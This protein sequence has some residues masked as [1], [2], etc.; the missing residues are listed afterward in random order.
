MFVLVVLWCVVSVSRLWILVVVAHN[1]K[2][3]SISACSICRPSMFV[4]V[5]LWCVVSVSR[6]WI[7]VVVAHNLKS[8][9]ISACNTYKPWMSHGPEQSNPP[10]PQLK[11]T[12]LVPPERHALLHLR[13]G[14]IWCIAAHT[15][16][17]AT[18]CANTVLNT[19]Y[20]Q[21]AFGQLPKIMIWATVH[22]FGLG[23]SRSWGRT[24]QIRCDVI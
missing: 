13:C 6:L 10:P 19:S 11:L 17:S 15:L 9:S 21:Q 16:L 7:L 23:W 18:T 14:R 24:H 22:P 20:T 3:S 8:S 5:V 4:L 2:S 12:V 1:L